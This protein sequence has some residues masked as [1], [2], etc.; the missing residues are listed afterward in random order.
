MSASAQ[1]GDASS[2]KCSIAQLDSQNRKFPPILIITKAKNPH[3]FVCK[4]EMSGL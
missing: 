3:F 1:I 4:A 2:L